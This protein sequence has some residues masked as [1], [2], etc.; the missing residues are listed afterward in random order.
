L[1]E[2]LVHIPHLG[3][4]EEAPVSPR[5]PSLVRGALRASRTKVPLWAGQESNLRPWD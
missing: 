1:C 3:A 2:K 4:L 5:P